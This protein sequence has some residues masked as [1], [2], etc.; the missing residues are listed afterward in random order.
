MH[1][2]AFLNEAVLQVR[3]DAGDRQVPGA[4]VAVVA[5]AH[6]PQCGAMVVRR[7]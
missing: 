5:N 1:G 3:G 4:R 2:L 7:V 6:G